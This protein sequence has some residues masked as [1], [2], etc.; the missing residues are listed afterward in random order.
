MVSMVPVNGILSTLVITS[1]VMF[2][3]VL[4]ILT[5]KFAITFSIIFWVGT[6]LIAVL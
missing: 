2:F 3:V 4:T 5:L 1:S 6:I